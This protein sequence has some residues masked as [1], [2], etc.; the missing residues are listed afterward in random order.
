M[1]SIRTRK[2]VLVTASPV[3]DQVISSVVG[4]S[5]Y[6]VSHDHSYIP[7]IL[8]EHLGDTMSLTQPYLPFDIAR[9]A[10]H[11]T[12]LGDA[13]YILRSTSNMNIVIFEPHVELSRLILATNSCPID[14]VV[15]PVGYQPDQVLTEL[16]FPNGEGLTLPLFGGCDHL[17]G[18]GRHAAP[19][20]P[21]TLANMDSNQ[22]NKFVEDAFSAW[23]VNSFKQE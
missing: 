13:S 7:R 23:V 14:G 21:D 15:I 6:V 2:T 1:G 18:Y 3:E 22:K 9:L 10:E 20:N 4:L 11:V 17:P 8:Q 12:L 5:D 19:V 16:G